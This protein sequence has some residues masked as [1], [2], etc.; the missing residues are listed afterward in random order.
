MWRLDA[1]ILQSKSDFAKYGRARV[2][3]RAVGRTE[4]KLFPDYEA[5]AGGGIT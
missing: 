4:K 2:G 1:G 3:D 5:S